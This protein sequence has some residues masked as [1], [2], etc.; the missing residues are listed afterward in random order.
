MNEGPIGFDLREATMKFMLMFVDDEMALG[1]LPAAEMDRIARE[2]TR[3]GQ[4][5]W[6][7]GKQVASQRLWPTAT[8]TRLS[9]RDGKVVAVD[10]PFTETK[11]VLLGF[12]VVECA[13]REEA[14]DWARKFLVFESATV[15]VRPVWERCL[16]HGAFDCSSRV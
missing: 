6:S 2:K 13:S 9:L 1:N 16:C 7:Q 15:E 14:L 4:E 11:E 5:L 8:A 3:V 10:G 12:H